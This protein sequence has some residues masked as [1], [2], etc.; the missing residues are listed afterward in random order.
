MK[1]S[2]KLKKV[3]FKLSNLYF[4]FNNLSPERLQEIVNH[5]RMTGLIL[6]LCSC[7]KGYFVAMSKEEMFEYLDGLG[8]RIDSQQKVHDALVYQIKRF[9]EL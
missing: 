9:N 3:L 4:P 2:K 8:Q 1:I 7:Q 5:I 6:N